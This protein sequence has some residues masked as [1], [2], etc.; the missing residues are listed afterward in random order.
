MHPPGKTRFAGARRAN[1]ASREDNSGIAAARAAGT[2]P[3]SWYAVYTR[4]NAERRV[5]AEL[6]DASFTAYLP[7][8]AETRRWSDRVKRVARVLFPGYVFVRMTDT[9]MNRVRVLRSAG[10]VR[11][12]GGAGRIEV[13][14]ERELNALQRCIESGSD[15]SVLPY[16]PSGQKVRVVRGPLQGVEGELVR[17]KDVIHLVVSVRLLSRFV[18]T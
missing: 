12:L 16:A 9:A 2:K 5:L 18:A 6:K 1:Q 3:E 11:I 14:P 8:V 7:M 13:I 10:V 17:L 15:L 4:S